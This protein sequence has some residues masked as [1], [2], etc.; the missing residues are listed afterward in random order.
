MWLLAG[1]SKISSFSFLKGKNAAY[2]QQSALLCICDI[3]PKTV[4]MVKNGK[5]KAKKLAIMVKKGKKCKLCHD[6]KNVHLGA[7]NVWPWAKNLMHDA[8]IVRYGAKNVKHG[9]KNV[10]NGAKNV[11][12]GAKNMQHDA[13]NVRHGAKNVQYGAKNVRHGA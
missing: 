10:R 1:N 2:G 13:K 5:K 8:K 9:A 12:H 11:R 4:N 6:A 3:Q 7:K